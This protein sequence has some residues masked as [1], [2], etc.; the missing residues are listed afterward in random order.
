MKVTQDILPPP[1]PPFNLIH[2]RR[3]NSKLHNGM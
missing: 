1:T 2:Q 3:W